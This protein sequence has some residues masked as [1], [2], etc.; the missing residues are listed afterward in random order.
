M[1]LALVMFL[2]VPAWKHRQKEDA[3]GRYA[4]YRFDLSLT[5]DQL[6]HDPYWQEL[7]NSNQAIETTPLSQLP[8]TA[9]HTDTFVPPSGGGNFGIHDNPA[10]RSTVLGPPAVPGPQPPSGPTPPVSG[11]INSKPKA[12]ASPHTARSP[13]TARA[14]AAPAAPVISVAGVVYNIEI[15]ELAAIRDALNN[16]NSSELLTDSR[17]NSAFYNISITRWSERRSDLIYRNA[18][19]DRCEA[20]D[21][22]E[23]TT[24]KTDVPVI[25]PKV[26]LGCLTLAD[27]RELAAFEEPAISPDL[28]GG[29]VGKEIDVSPGALPRDL[30]AAS[31]VAETLFI[32]V[33]LY[34]GAFVRE[35]SASSGFP[36]SGTLFSAFSRSRVTLIAM[37]VAFL[38]PVAS[39]VALALVAR[40][41]LLWIGSLLILGTVSTVFAELQKRSYFSPLNPFG[42]IRRAPNPGPNLSTGSDST[43]ASTSNPEVARQDQSDSLDFFGD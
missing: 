37:F 5:I 22:E 12:L 36:L 6:D 42:W 16:L 24:R 38:T 19:L 23:P 40:R 43:C 9:V 31:I 21:I 14:G 10:S 33:M 39:S 28:I 30:Y 41:S 2:L 25:F 29:T 3:L 15:P 18:V 1:A 4:A 27:I 8:T 7:K 11:P 26:L 20:E 13:K 34:F 32:F 17:D 35:T